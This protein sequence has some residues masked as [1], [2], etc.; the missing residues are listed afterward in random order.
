[1]CLIFFSLHKHMGNLCPPGHRQEA[2]LD[3]S[4]PNPVF[5]KPGPNDKTKTPPSPGR[6]PLINNS[7]SDKTSPSQPRQS[8]PE[9][10]E[11]RD[12]YHPKASIPFSCSS[13]CLS[14]SIWLSKY[15]V[16]LLSIHS[17]HVPVSV[18]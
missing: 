3:P 16:T 5:S 9:V 17:T 4:K 8:K 12:N 7:P 18:G 11:V 14:F 2:S 6:E 1:M 10:S 13:P 15:Q